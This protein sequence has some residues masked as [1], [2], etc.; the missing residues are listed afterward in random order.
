M[1]WSSAPARGART[2][3]ALTISVPAPDGGFERFAVAESPVMEPALAA[4]HPEIKTYTARGLDDPSA[5]ARLDLTP[6]G[7]H[8]AV[9]SASGAWYVDPRGGKHVAYRRDAPATAQPFGEPARRA[10]SRPPPRP[11]RPRRAATRSRCASTG[12]R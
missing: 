8:A 12:S 7:F 3:R 11:G 5:S 10:A 6:L 1:C 9:R 4:A 2:V